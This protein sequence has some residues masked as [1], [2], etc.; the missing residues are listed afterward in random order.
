MQLPPTVASGEPALSILV[1]LPAAAHMAQNASPIAPL[2]RPSPLVSRKSGST[3]P[4][5]SSLNSN[6]PT[7]PSRLRIDDHSPEAGHAELAS[8]PVVH[9]L[10]GRRSSLA[11]GL[12]GGTEIRSPEVRGNS[13]LGTIEP[14]P[15]GTPERSPSPSPSPGAGSTTNPALSNY[16]FASTTEAPV[17]EAVTQEATSSTSTTA[18][19]LPTISV[20]A[21]AFGSRK[22]LSSTGGPPGRSRRRPQTA[23]GSGGNGAAQRGSLALPS[24]TGLGLGGGLHSRNRPGWE[25]EEIVSNLRNSGLEGTCGSRVSARSGRCRM[26]ELRPLP[27]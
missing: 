24:G 8:V 25:A 12:G 4:S 11:P 1:L 9:N 2:P 22:P 21:P 26:S 17:S 10:P 14:S 15:P 19:T 6:P 5:L 20:E 23:A 13:K 16:R 7:Q 3:V 18:P 27:K